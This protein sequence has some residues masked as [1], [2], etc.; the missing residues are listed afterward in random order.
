MANRWKSRIHLTAGT[1]DTCLIFT[2]E[3]PSGD[4]NLLPTFSSEDPFKLRAVPPRDVLQATT[5]A[6]LQQAIER[7]DVNHE[8]CKLNRNASFLPTRLIDVR[9]ENVVRLVV[10]HHNQQRRRLLEQCMEIRGS[11]LLLGPQVPHRVSAENHRGQSRCPFHR[12][13]HGHDASF[14]PGRHLHNQGARRPVSL[15]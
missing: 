2:V 1:N 15:G 11:E 10:F 9:E 5:K 6:F 4:M 12:D 13:S 14:A 3:D 7:C 8:E